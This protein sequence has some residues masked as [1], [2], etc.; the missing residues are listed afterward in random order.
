[1]KNTFC[2]PLLC[3]C[4][5]VHAQQ[6]DSSGYYF[7]MAMDEKNAGLY[8]KAAQHF[9]KTVSLDPHNAEAY[10]Q[11]GYTQ[12]HMKKQDAAKANF[13]KVMELSPANKE[14][15]RELMELFYNYRQYTDAIALANLNPEAENSQRILGMSYYQTEDYMNAEKYLK[16]AIQKNPQDAEVTYTLGRN[17]LDM[18][19][20]RKAVPYYEKAISMESA[21]PAWIYELGLLYYNLNDYK[22]ALASFKNAADHGYNRSSDFNENMGYASLYCGEYDAGETL[23]YD[24]WRKKPGNRDI[25]RDM[26]EILYQQKQYERSLAYCQK[27]M[28]LDM[29]DAK[30]LYQAGL[31]FQK[32][33][34]KDRGQQMC[35]KAIQMDPSLESLRRKKEM[36]G[37]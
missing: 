19:E 18:E 10:L 1:M 23:L 4:L 37:L 14:A 29:N 17:Y 36:V 6:T 5:S 26:A 12:L 33:G 2:I 35:D 28:E 9:E 30:A 31:C 11:N 34:Q 13:L 15:S 22:H 7:K 16:A 3:T 21:K 24:I 8:L 25:I 20:Y 27:L 32:K